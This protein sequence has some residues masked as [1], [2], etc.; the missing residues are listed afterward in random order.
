MKSSNSG[1]YSGC[2]KKLYTP[3]GFDT[4]VPQDIDVTRAPTASK[5]VNSSDG[6]ASK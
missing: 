5:T 1:T 3:G 6:I 4:D 2:E